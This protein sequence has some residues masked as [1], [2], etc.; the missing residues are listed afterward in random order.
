MLLEKEPNNRRVMKHSVE[1]GLPSMSRSIEDLIT[2]TEPGTPPPPTVKKA[3]ETSPPSME[4]VRVQS[5]K[6]MRKYVRLG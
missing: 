1:L 2:I 5:T 6:R 4:G 3:P